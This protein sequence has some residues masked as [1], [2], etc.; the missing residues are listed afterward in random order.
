[1]PEN[2]F[3]V[4]NIKETAVAELEKACKIE[5]DNTVF[6]LTLG[7]TYNKLGMYDKAISIYEIIVSDEEDNVETLHKLAEL[8]FILKQY[9]KAADYYKEIIK[10]N[11]YDGQAAIGYIDSIYIDYAEAD[12][13]EK[14]FYDFKKKFKDDAESKTKDAMAYF[15]MGY[16]FMTLIPTISM[17]TE[18]KVSAVSAFKMAISIDPDFLWP[19]FA[20][21]RLQTKE[22]INSEEPDYT[23]AIDIAR[24][25]VERNPNDAWARF[26]L[27]EA[28][29]ENLKVNMKNDAIEEYRN[30][31]RINNDFVEAHF[32]LASLYKTKNMLQESMKEYNRVI[33]LKPNSSFAKDARRSLLYIEKNLAK[34]K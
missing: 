26:E 23:G 28:Y 31:I 2:A 27:A 18:D 15:L 33:E 22:G 29:N 12:E 19:Y 25:A 34:K 8:N 17:T 30:A 13:K 24:K 9:K 3:T 14:K 1:M 32:K 7:D 16:S 11:S 21:R 10:Y 4:A 20:M 6:R 5:K